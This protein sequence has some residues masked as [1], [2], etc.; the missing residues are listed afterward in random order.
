MQNCR[1]FANADAKPVLGSG[2]NWP[3]P[4]SVPRGLART[5]RAPATIRDAPERGNRDR[6]R[7]FM[8]AASFEAGTATCEAGE[9]WRCMMPL[10][11]GKAWSQRGLAGALA[12][13]VSQAWR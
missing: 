2:L 6:S 4:R 3:R 10:A 11:M 13:R 1:P 5:P 12:A 9:A 7:R 8:G